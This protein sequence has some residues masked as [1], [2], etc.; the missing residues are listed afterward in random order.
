[1]SV[2]RAPRAFPC[3]GR[4]G[5]CRGAG[6]FQGLPGHQGGVR[7][8]PG[9]PLADLRRLLYCGE[10]IS[11]HALHVYTLHTPELL[12]HPGAVEL[13]RD[14]RPVVERGLS[15]RPAANLVM[16]VLGGR[17]I[18]PVNV[19]VGGFYRVLTAANWRR[20]PNGCAGRWT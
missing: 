14:H 8:Q 6:I 4:L 15:L 3:A 19:R 13:A 2:V 12:S 20:S 9:G 5:R 1:V 17:S 7:G 16:E 10:W 18:H 11:S